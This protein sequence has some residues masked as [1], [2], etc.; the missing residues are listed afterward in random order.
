MRLYLSRP[1][2]GSVLLRPLPGAPLHMPH[3]VSGGS[4]NP[5]TP[6]SPAR[7]RRRCATGPGKRSPQ[8]K[9][10]W[11]AQYPV[12]GESANVGAPGGRSG[13]PALHRGGVHHPEVVKE[14][15]GV[16]G[17][18]PDQGPQLGNRGPDRLL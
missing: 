11:L 7:P 3:G 5:P 2:G 6:P 4:T 14:Q 8:K 17:E 12:A 13:A 9:R 18:D 10:E 15:V 16:G 1:C